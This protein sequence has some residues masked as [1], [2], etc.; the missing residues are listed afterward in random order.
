MRKIVKMLIHN[1]ELLIWQL[2][3]LTFQLINWVGWDGVGVARGVGGRC[4]CLFR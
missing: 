2:L 1:M 3:W 4:Y